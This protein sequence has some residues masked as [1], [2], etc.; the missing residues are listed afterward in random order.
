MAK[1]DAAPNKPEN[2]SVYAGGCKEA[3]KPSPSPAQWGSRAQKLGGTLAAHH[4]WDFF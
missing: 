1:L 2:L 4:C 3:D